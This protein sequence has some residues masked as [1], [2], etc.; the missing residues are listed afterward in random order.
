M[1]Y[2][3]LTDRIG[4]N[5][6]Q[7]AAGASLAYRHKVDYAVCIPDFML[8]DGS[9]L[10][11]YIEQYKDNIF[12]KISFVTEVPEDVGEYYQSGF[13]FTPL[14][15]RRR[16]CLNGYFQ[17]EKY[18]EREYI[19]DLFSI[20]DAT[21]EYINKRYGE[22]FRGEINSLH[23]RR[24]D[25]LKRPQR[26]PVC[27][28]RYYKEAINIL[29]KYKKYLVLSDDIEWCKK[30]FKGDNFFFSEK[31]D[32]IV[33]LYLQTMCN[34][35]IIS[36]SSFSW[37]GAWLNSNPHKKVIAPRQWFGK[38]MSEWDMSD[39]IPEEWIRIDNPK[40]LSLKAKIVIYDVKDV[41][42]KVSRRIGY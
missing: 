2:S 4:N 1:V 22:L 3:M 25:Y 28:F 40:S 29:G 9:D 38:Q 17:S 26:Q 35:N 21:L 37:W 11:N 14:E 8:P 10:E 27:S 30:H 12:R 31:E 42:G 41:F 19:K 33:D 23:V 16:V 13:H 18:F 6:F 5:L 15:Y 34:N 32:S 24:G 39:L 7:V 20:D 36:N